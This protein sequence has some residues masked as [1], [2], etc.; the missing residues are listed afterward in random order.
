VCPDAVIARTSLVIGDQRSEHVRLVQDLV[1]G[2]RAGVL[3]TDGTHCPVHASDLAAVLLEL[4]FS[5]AS[6]VRDLAGADALSRHKLGVPIARSDGLDTS[7]LPKGLRAHSKLSGPPDV[8]LDGRESQRRLSTTL[9]GARQFCEEATAD[10]LDPG[11]DDHRTAPT[12][13]R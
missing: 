13:G 9:R 6:G 10:D 1:V 2:R 3:F 4:A 7:Q 11:R 5:N 12:I 8:R